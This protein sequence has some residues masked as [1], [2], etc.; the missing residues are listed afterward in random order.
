MLLLGVVGVVELV[1]SEGGDAGLDAAGAE[2]DEVESEE[3]HRVLCH[4]GFAVLGFFVA[5]WSYAGN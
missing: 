1:G 2:G 3:G 4:R 5:C